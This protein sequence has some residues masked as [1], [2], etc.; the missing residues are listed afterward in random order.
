MMVQRRGYCHKIVVKNK[1][2]D[3][4]LARSRGTISTTGL[5]IDRERADSSNTA[6]R[7]PMRAAHEFLAAEFVRIPNCS[8]L[9][10]SEFWRIRLQS[11]NEALLNCF[12][13]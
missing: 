3:S 12:L 7:P 11:S 4:C 10:E 8:A 6:D 1:R 9:Q 2:S 13:S 5:E